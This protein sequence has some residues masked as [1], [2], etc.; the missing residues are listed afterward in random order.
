MSRYGGG[1]ESRSGGGAKWEGGGL[2][3]FRCAGSVC[4]MVALE[5]GGSGYLPDVVTSAMGGG[6][7]SGGAGG[8]KLQVACCLIFFLFFFQEHV[9]ALNRHCLT[10]RA[11]VRSLD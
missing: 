4:G 2:A 11:R 7:R 8:R 10:A 1:G 9:E 6:S 3:G 5:G